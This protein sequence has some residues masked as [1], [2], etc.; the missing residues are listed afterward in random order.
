MLAYY[1][2]DGELYIIITVILF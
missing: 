1:I 2:P